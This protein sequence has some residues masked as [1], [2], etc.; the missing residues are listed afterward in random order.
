MVQWGYFISE[1]LYEFAK[2]C[3]HSNNTLFQFNKVR[4]WEHLY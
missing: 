3:K 1:I 4:G 2:T